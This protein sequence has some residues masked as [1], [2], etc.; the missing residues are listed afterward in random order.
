VASIAG[1]L[2]VLFL[3]FAYVGQHGAGK[4][5]QVV[6]NT[7]LPA[8]REGRHIVTNIPLCLDEIVADYPKADVRVV[9]TDWFQDDENIA[10]IPGG[11]LIVID[12]AQR[13]FPAGQAVNKVSQVRSDFFATHRHKVFKGLS[14]DIGVITQDLGKV[15]NWVRLDV[16]KTFVAT[17]L[18]AVGMD[19]KFRIGIYQGPVKGPRY[20]EP[21]LGFTIQEY[22]PEVFKYYRSHTMGGGQVGA[23]IKPDKRATVLSHPMVKYGI[24]LGIIAGLFALWSVIGFFV[25]HQKKGESSNDPKHENSVSPVRA[26]VA[27]PAPVVSRGSEVQ[28]LSSVAADSV[29]PGPAPGRGSGVEPKPAPIQPYS[30]EW[31]VSG[32]ALMDGRPVVHVEGAKG[33][34]R[35]LFGNE[36]QGR[37]LDSVVCLVEGKRVASW[38]GPAKDNG[39]RTIAE[40]NP[41]NKP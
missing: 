6:E 4:S 1:A 23:E 35:R 24:P 20:P 19:H 34:K 29:V 25:S 10:A 37:T 18:D 17:K 28:P 27:A 16:N 14:Q 22:R 3:V 15:A 26:A 9:S 8:C 21:D 31:R 30:D 32:F 33:R 38:T 5:Y 11:A 2:V 39:V 13:V 41:M 7:I 12:E 40:L 36:C